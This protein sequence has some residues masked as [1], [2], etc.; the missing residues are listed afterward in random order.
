[1]ATTPNSLLLAILSNT[2]TQNYLQEMLY[3]SNFTLEFCT[4][5]EQALPEAHNLLPDAI[6]L[7]SDLPNFDCN[8]IC[9]RLKADPHLKGVPVVMLVDLNDRK[10]KAKALSAGADDFLNKP[11]DGIELL[12]RL[13]T[14]TRL[15][16]YDQLFADL[17]RFDWMVAH[18][19]EGYLILD[20]DSIIQYA[21]ERAVNMLNLPENPDGLDFT[22]VVEANYVAR[23]TES[24]KTWQQDPSP[25]FLMRPENINAR[26]FWMVLEALDT[27]IGAAT[28]RIV[29]LR[30]VTEKMSIYQDIRRFHDTITHKLRTP[31]SILATSVSLLNSQIEHL[32]PEEVKE[33]AVSAAKGAERLVWEVRDVLTY[34]DAPLAINIGEPLWLKHLPRMIQAIAQKINLKHLNFSLPECYENERISLT[35]DAFE[36]VLTEA[37]ENT[38][39]FHPQHDPKVDISI[40]Q[41]ESGLIHFRIID[42][43]VNLS[44]EQLSWAWLPYF[45][46]EKTFTGELPGMGLGFPLMATL[47]WG[48]GGTLRLSNRPDRPG[49]LVEMKI[50]TIRE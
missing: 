34:I 16:H 14:L 36:L 48:A 4:E 46:G 42:D 2:Y 10:A 49:I 11:F 22:Q 21:N 7:D 1:M 25:C 6:L 12:V 3:R 13:R 33:L 47:I 24:W 31:I 50:P 37:L 30:D 45:Q 41:T 17:E 23:P 8:E 40:G 29:R 27:S 5:P 35:P 19:Q 18:A 9:R 39:K 15:H 26:A 28:Q 44:A 38:K 32:S 20:N 43:G